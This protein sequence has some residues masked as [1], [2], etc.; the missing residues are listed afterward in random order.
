MNQKRTFDQIDPN[1]M[2]NYVA[3]FRSMGAI[4]LLRDATIDSYADDDDQDANWAECK[5]FAAAAVDIAMLML[6]HIGVEDGPEFMREAAQASWP[7]AQA[8]SR[9]AKRIIIETQLRENQNGQA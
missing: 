5:A 7:D 1:L 3:V 8:A 4:C 9:E 2:E 6:A